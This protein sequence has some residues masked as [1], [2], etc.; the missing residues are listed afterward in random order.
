MIYYLTGIFYTNHAHLVWENV[1]IDL[2]CTFGKYPTSDYYNFHEDR[3]AGRTCY[4]NVYDDV[5]T[6]SGSATKVTSIPVTPTTAQMDDTEEANQSFVAS[7]QGVFLSYAETY[8]E[9]TWNGDCRAGYSYDGDRYYS[10]I[11]SSLSDIYVAFEDNKGRKDISIKEIFGIQVLTTITKH[12]YY[13]DDWHNSVLFD[14]A[15]TNT[16]IPDVSVPAE[17]EVYISDDTRCNVNFIPIPQKLNTPY[18]H[19]PQEV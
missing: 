5:Q 1:G 10:K 3:L 14:G 15:C 4:V 17:G 11:R 13:D 6:A 2:F 16:F 9:K 8:Q 19:E 18:Y 7:L 12:V